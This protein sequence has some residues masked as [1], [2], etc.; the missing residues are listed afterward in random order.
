MSERKIIEENDDGGGFGLPP[1]F[2]EGGWLFGGSVTEA[3]MWLDANGDIHIQRCGECS[4]FVERQIQE[5]IDLLQDLPVD[6]F[7][8]GGAQGG[9]IAIHPDALED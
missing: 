6:C 5:Q 9:T 1:I 4:A 3:S 7:V 8:C 2:H